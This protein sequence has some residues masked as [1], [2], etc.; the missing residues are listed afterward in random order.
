LDVEDA[1]FKGKVKVHTLPDGTE[2]LADPVTG[3]PFTS[4][5]DLLTVGR[6]GE[7]SDTLIMTED[8]GV[9]APEDRGT[10]ED[11]NDAVGHSGGDVVQHGAAGNAPVTQ[12][13]NYPL[14]AI[15]P[16]GDIV[17]IGSESM[18]PAENQ[19]ALQDYLSAQQAQGNNFA[20]DPAWGL[21]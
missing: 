12:D 10:I 4:D 7:P 19:Q 13:I 17:S 3:K 8:Q 14:T 5:Y 21:Q 2:V 6:K 18:S 11:V 9:M 15:E 16:N 20:L 1:I